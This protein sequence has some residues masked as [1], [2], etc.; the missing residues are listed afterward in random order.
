MSL[1][2]SPWP[3]GMPC[4]VDLATSDVDGA[5][6]FYAGI[7]GWEYDRTDQESGGYVLARTRGRAA[8][9]IGPLPRPG[10]PSAWTVYLATDDADATAAALDG[11]GGSVLQAPV[12]QAPVEAGPSGRRVVATDPSGAVFGL[13][14][15]GSFIGA[16][17]V[18]EDGALMWEDLRSTDPDAARAFFAGLF[19]Y[20]YDGIPDA[21]PDYTTFAFPGQGATPLGGMGGM[22]G[23]P[24]EVGSHWLVYFAVPDAAQAVATAELTGG[25]V[26]MPTVASPY[27]T[28]AALADP[29]GATF[30]VMQAPEAAPQP[31]R[32]D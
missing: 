30:V 28:M 29:T 20:E 12:D 31:D 22:M 5:L 8:A 17:V 32:G 10:L 9:G 1:R 26:L 21:G 6:A 3:P 14:Q 19:G 24:A 27:G 11:L 25:T 7:V 15:A 2:S 16:G 23:A 18:N 13:W 4:W